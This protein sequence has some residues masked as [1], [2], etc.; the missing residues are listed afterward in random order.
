MIGHKEGDMVSKEFIARLLDD[1]RSRAELEN[2]AGV[3]RGF[4]RDIET[5]R[6][7]P[8]RGDPRVVALGREL[9]LGFDECF[10]RYGAND[11]TI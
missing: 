5:G 3:S 6:K 11:E 4:I 1:P 7:R 9:G 10:R 8:R 2:L